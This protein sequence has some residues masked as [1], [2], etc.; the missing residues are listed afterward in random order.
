M[1]LGNRTVASWNV[2]EAGGLGQRR[3]GVGVGSTGEVDLPCLARTTGERLM[4][5]GVGV[6]EAGLL[7]PVR[8]EAGG[9]LEIR[10]VLDEG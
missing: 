9:E 8:V 6:D 5:G 3:P 4:H 7:G 2:A 1:G 10:L